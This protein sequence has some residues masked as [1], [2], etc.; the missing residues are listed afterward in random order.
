MREPITIT[1][2]DP[3]MPPFHRALIRTV[4]KVTGRGALSERYKRYLQDG[5]SLSGPAAWDLAVK[6][7]GIR[8]D[9]AATPALKRPDRGLL[10]VANHPFGVI[11]G[12]VLSWI[13]SRIDPEF[14]VIANGVLLQEPSLV[15]NLLPIDFTGTR[16]ANR[17]NVASR[18][19]AIDRLRNSGT[20]GIFPAGGVSWSQRRRAPV[21]DDEWKPM[22]GKLIQASRCDILPV[23]FHGRNSWSFQFASRHSQVL[24]LGL[25]LN[26]VRNKLDTRIDVDIGQRIDFESLPDLEPL[27]LT[28]HLRQRMGV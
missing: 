18:R 12:F 11:D 20:I 19:A 10:L 23:Q 1:Y 2:A 15:R 6:Q 22:T 13:A 16:D 4:E 26:E 14:Q 9:A 17:I 24:R 5:A 28:Q 27:E 21:R 7:L 25:L 8:F 3:S